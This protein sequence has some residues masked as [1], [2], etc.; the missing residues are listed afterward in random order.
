MAR[1]ST[2]AAERHGSFAGA[3]RHCHIRETSAVPILMLTV[4]DST[5]DKVRALDLGADDY[6]VKPF[7]HLELLARLRVLLRRSQGA[8]GVGGA[9]PTLIV[10]DVSLNLAS[11]DA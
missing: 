11:H 8:A 6:L 7:D 2:G 5:L 3:A 10:G 1:S 4:R 9:P